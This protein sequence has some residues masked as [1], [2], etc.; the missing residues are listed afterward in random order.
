MKQFVAPPQALCDQHETL[1][2]VSVPLSFAQQRLWLLDQFDADTATSMSLVLRLTG[3]LRVE[4]LKCALGEIVRRHKILRSSFKDGPGGPQQHVVEQPDLALALT[5]LSGMT[6]AEGEA[7]VAALVNAEAHLPIDLVAGPLL[8]VALVRLE[9]EVHIVL[10]TVHGIAADNWSMRVFVQELAAR[11]RT[12]SDQLPCSLPAF[13]VQYTDFAH[14]QHQCLESGA[15]DRQLAYWRTELDGVPALL[16]LPTD[17][18][19]PAVQ[20]LAGASVRCVVAAGLAEALRELTGA[21]R[22]SL[23][24][25]LDAVF[26]VLLLRYTGQMDLC[27]GTQVENRGSADTHALIGVVANTLVLRTQVDPR[28]TFL[29]LLQRVRDTVRDA[30]DNK[31]VPFEHLL[32]VLRPP[33]HLSHTPLFQVMLMLT[34]APAEILDLPGLRLEALEVRQ[35]ARCDLTLAVTEM[36]GELHC[37]FRYSAELFDRETIERM[38]RHFTRLIES[39]VAAPSARL[40]ALPMLSREETAQ[41]VVEWN[42]TTSPYPRAQT[43]MQLFERQARRH[44][45]AQALV[46]EQHTLNYAE[47][48][49]K[50]NQLAHYLR[51][52]GVRPEVVVAVAVERSLEMVVALLAVLKAGGTYLPLD[53]AYPHDRLAHMLDDSR[54][55]VLLTQ[56]HLQQTLPGAQLPSVCLDQWNQLA[57]WPTYDPA[58]RVLPDQLAYVIYTSGSTGRPKGVAVSH[59][60]LVNFLSSMARYPGTTAADTFLAV[61]SISF[62]MAVLDLFLPLVSG[63]R[64][65]LASRWDAGDPQS[66]LELIEQ[67]HVTIMQA[68]PASWEMLTQ[69]IAGTAQRLPRAWCGGAPLSVPLARTLAHHCAAVINLYGPTETTVYSSIGAGFGDGV[70]MSIGRPIANSQ[71]YLLDAALQPVPIGVT[72]ELY[73]GGDGLARGYLGQPSLTAER[74]LPNPFSQFPGGRMYRTGDLARYL[75]NGNIEYLG[76][77][78][79]QIKLRGFR[80]ELGEIEAVL[81]AVD[82]VA[83]AAVLALAPDG[84]ELRLVAYVTRQPGYQG[85]GE[86]DWRAALM[87]TLPDYMV[88][89]QF[90]VLERLPLTPNGKLDRMALPTPRKSGH[91]TQSAVLATPTERAL[92][93]IWAALLELEHIGAGDDFFERGGH[94]MLATQLVSQLRTQFEVSLS[95]RELFEYTQL[96]ALAKRIDALRQQAQGQEPPCVGSGQAWGVICPELYT[97]EGGCFNFEFDGVAYNLAGDRVITQIVDRIFFSRN[98]SCRSALTHDPA[99]RRWREDWLALF[100]TYGGQVSRRASA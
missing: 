61:A 1:R 69:R 59:G 66:L 63:A 18:P 87:R 21:E 35:P 33:R 3:L 97:T 11:Y 75:L 96:A 9:A 85:S 22:S 23:F 68:T 93:S 64:I 99:H 88:P 82:G 50:A 81:V 78:D 39:A 36:V 28:E 72:G 12:L 19:R 15:F 100:S 49:A 32:E 4:L 70:H 37:D 24:M 51:S 83:E 29:Q 86:A 57:A 73:I 44:P 56:T 14:W 48:N 52:L 79:H 40:D 38:A 94:S 20:C 27:I 54:A 43:V 77:A 42:A 55:T 30:E 46:C 2:N 67:H 31:D 58:P 98:P 90:V 10:L 92:A 76:R 6:P 13:P 53:P 16:A 65:I 60:S 7:C 84:G 8:R 45:Q 89:S 80:I 71:I 74:F 62:D 26:K 41:M 5:D 95:F 17:R 47:L 25:G 91:T 34:P